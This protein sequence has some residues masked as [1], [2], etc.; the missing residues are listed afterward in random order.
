MN[1][2]PTTATFHVLD[3]DLW[4][5]SY[6]QIKLGVDLRRNVTVIRLK[7][8]ELIIHST[9]PF[10]AED[11]H[12]IHE[13]GTPAWLVDAMLHHD[14]YAHEGR[15]SFPDIPYLAPLGF[16]A[17]AGFATIPLLPPPEA[18]K[19]EV[20]V[21]E[22]QGMTGF[23]EHVFFHRASRTLIVADLMFNFG[24]DEPWWKEWLL[25]LAVTGDHNPGMSRAFKLAITDEAQFKSSVAGILAWDFDRVIVGHGEMI[26]SGGKDMLISMLHQAGL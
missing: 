26:E 20:D 6:P 21:L 3:Q 14:T 25:K 23:Q 7:S 11:I 2:A 18:W 12:A 13:M 9:A 17:H 1:L 22:L 4:L 8:G 24:Q 19:D 16:S 5:L 10:S 15:V